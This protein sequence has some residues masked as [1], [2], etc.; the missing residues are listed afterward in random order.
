MLQRAN[1]FEK[2]PI[3]IFICWC[4]CPAVAEITNSYFVQRR[5]Y[6]CCFCCLCPTWYWSLVGTAPTQFRPTPWG[7]CGLCNTFAAAPSYE[8]LVC[9][10]AQLS[11]VITQRAAP[12]IHIY[13]YTLYGGTQPGASG[14]ILCVCAFIC[15]GE[16]CVRDL[17]LELG[18]N[19][20]FRL[21]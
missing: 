5:P 11:D 1:P 13:M 16:I 3:W 20:V 9:R 10:L 18:L 2:I 12:Y 8:R 14:G 17:W 4:L 21:I 19:I 7:C 15:N 6:G